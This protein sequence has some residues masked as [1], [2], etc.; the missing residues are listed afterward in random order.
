MSLQKPN[1]KLYNKLLASMI[2]TSK[3]QKFLPNYLVSDY[4]ILKKKGLRLQNEATQIKLTSR[5]Q[6]VL[7]VQLVLSHLSRMKNHDDAT[8]RIYA[9][10]YNLGMQIVFGNQPESYFEYMMVCQNL[11]RNDYSVR[12]STRGRRTLFHL[13]LWEPNKINIGTLY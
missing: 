6:D 5:T 2:A 12:H 13:I 7:A 11:L 9:R 8:D 3:K 4:T 10:D 1:K